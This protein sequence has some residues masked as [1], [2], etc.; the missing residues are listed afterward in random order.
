[1]TCDNSRVGASAAT[2]TTK[3]SSALWEASD[4]VSGKRLM[5]MIPILRERAP[6]AWQHPVGACRRSIRRHVTSFSL[7][8][9]PAPGQRWERQNL[10]AEPRSR[11]APIPGVESLR[12]SITFRNLLERDA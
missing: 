12:H 4:R 10:I 11:L 9:P 8:F 1:M 2:R 5:A 6:I 7:H 3:T